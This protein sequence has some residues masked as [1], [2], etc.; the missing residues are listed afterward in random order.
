MDASA[1][2]AAPSRNSAVRRVAHRKGHGHSSVHS[3][4]RGIAS[5]AML[6]MTT[7]YWN[8]ISKLIRNDGDGIVARNSPETTTTAAVTIRVNPASFKITIA[9]GRTITGTVIRYLAT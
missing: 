9:Q 1:V 6:A 7:A 8:T 4:R 5:Q 3:P 2:P